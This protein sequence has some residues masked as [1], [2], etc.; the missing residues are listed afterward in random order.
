MTM[1]KLTMSKS[2]FLKFF[3]AAALAGGLFA[4]APDA[5]QAQRHGWHGGGGWHHGG[6]WHRGWH[7]GGWGGRRGWGWGPAVGLGIGA[8]GW[9]YPYGYYASGPYYAAPSCG[10]VRT[11]VWRHGY[12]VVR[13]VWRCW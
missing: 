8:W 5:A 9:G 1:S 10:W 13:R 3:A 2:K 4:F 12:V 7:G 11:R 6:G